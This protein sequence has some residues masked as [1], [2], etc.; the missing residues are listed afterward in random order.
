MKNF[1]HPLFQHAPFFCAAVAGGAFAGMIAAGIVTSRLFDERLQQDRTSVIPFASRA[2][3]TPAVTFVPVDSRPT[4]AFIPSA[5]LKRHESGTAAVYRK[6]KGQ[7]REERLLD[8]ERLLGQAVALTADGWFVTSAFLLSGQ[9]VSDVVLWHNGAS[10]AVERG[11][12]DHLNNTVYFKTRAQGLPVAAF[13]RVR[14]ITRGM[15]VWMETHSDSFAPRIVLDIGARVAPNDAV[16]SEVTARRVVLDGITPAGAR[17]SVVWDAGSALIGIVDSKEGEA[18]RVIPSATIAA[19]FSSLLDAGE[20]RHA[21]LGLRAI[22]LAHLRFDGARNGLSERGAWIRSLGTSKS[23]QR[24]TT[25]SASV[26]KVGDV[27]LRV[28]RDTLDGSADLGEI[29]ADYR[30]GTT[31]TMRILRD[32][33][34][35]DVQVKLGSAVTS[36]EI[37]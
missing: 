30:P 23:V 26:L 37:R 18:L 6:P 22:D 21:A 10:Y 20:I 2:T 4:R 28:E 8:S 33:R 3:S 24:E 7:T 27:I 12:V 9:R 15:D 13:A 19:S 25:S 14:D 1:L 16:S 31:I 34:D 29:L 36:E 32:T 5:F 17:G 35:M 11:V